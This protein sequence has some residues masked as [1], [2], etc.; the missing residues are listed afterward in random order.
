LLQ[1]LENFDRSD[2]SATKKIK[3]IFAPGVYGRM[4]R[5][6]RK[7]LR[8]H[9]GCDLL[10]G[11]AMG[12]FARIIG[13]C[14]VGCVAGPM[15]AN[16]ASAT[17]PG[18]FG[19]Y[20]R[21]VT[22]GDPFGAAPLPGVYFEN[23]TLYAPHSVGHGQV[24][25]FNASATSE[26][27]IV[28]WSTGWT[29]LNAKVV[30]AASEE[31]FE[32]NAW[33]SATAGP[34]FT[35]TTHYP[36]WHDTFLNPLTLSWELVPLKWYASAGLAF[37]VPDGSRY[38]NTPNPD[39]WTLEPNAALSY[40]G[41]G[42]DLT[43]RFVYDIN[44]ASAGHTGPFAGTPAA[45]FGIGYRSGDQLFVDLTATKKFGNWEIGPVGYIGGQLTSDHPGSGFSCA[46]MATVTGV[47]CGRATDI[48][49][50]GLIAYYPNLPNLTPALKLYITD[51][52]YTKDDFGGLVIWTKLSFKLPDLTQNPAPPAI[53][54]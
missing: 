39:Y 30:I 38:N 32:V 19:Q 52:V 47:T 20:F 46:T 44:G 50:G 36:A 8:A 22:I 54:K 16:S 18:D 6:R 34:P 7:S 10:D 35:D 15:L 41:D 24:G 40:I 12:V 23:V 53:H 4:P 27:P 28:I 1:F 2:I 37:F 11:G 49:I 29:F 48:A 33:S 31:Y 9:R 45:A 21:G 5:L 3:N 51:S 43:A 14:A 26:I 13:Y 25:A 17:E 42:W